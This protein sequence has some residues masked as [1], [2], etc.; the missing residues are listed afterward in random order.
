MNTQA[1][2]LG[3]H[4]SGTLL[5]TDYLNQCGLHIGDDLFGANATNHRGH[6]EDRA[7][8]RLHEAMLR[9]VGENWLAKAPFHPV[10]RRDDHKE[11]LRLLANRDVVRDLWGF[12]DPRT[13][14]LG[15][16]GTRTRR[17]LIICRAAQAFRVLYWQCAATCRSRC[18]NERR[19]AAATTRNS[20]LPGPHRGIVVASYG[21]RHRVHFENFGS[22]NRNKYSR[23]S[24]EEPAN[25]ADQ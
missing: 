22:L 15:T 21:A 9:R 25:P 8:F 11:A 7:M 24:V 2:I 1:I 18:E 3:F 4:R 17:I 6:F 5:F 20:E 12:K 14:L 23:T 13:C 19:G 10:Y 16:Y